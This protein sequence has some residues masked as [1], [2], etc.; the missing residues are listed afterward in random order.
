[1]KIAAPEGE[2]TSPP[3]SPG[4]PSGGAAAGDVDGAP[5]MSIGVAA[6]LGLVSS[7][8]TAF[9]AIA[10]SKVT[11]LVLGP[12]GIG[13][14]AEI[15]QLVTMANAPVGLTSGPSLIGAVAEAREKKDPAGVDAAYQTSLTGT[16]ILSVV[17]GLAAVLMGFWLLPEPWGASVWPLTALGAMTAVVTAW[18]GLV[19]QLLT[20]AGK[21]RLLAIVGVLTAAVGTVLVVIGTFFFGLAGQFVGVAIAGV[22]S[23][24]IAWAVT[25]RALPGV[26]LRP[27]WRFDGPYARRALH[28]GVAT[29]VAGV[30]TQ[31]ILFSIRWSLEARGGPALNG[32]FQAAWSIGGTYFALVLSS[33][34]NFSFP[35]YAAAPTP[36]ALEGEIRTAVKFILRTAPPIILI[37]IAFRVEIVRILYSHKF[38]DATDLLGLQMAGDLAKAVAWAQAGPL[39]YR[40]KV[41]AY[42]VTE[43]VGATLMIGTSLA[44][45][46]LFGLV[47]VGYAYIS[48]YVA[49]LIVTAL[50]V[51]RACGVTLG[52]S[53][54]LTTIAMTA[55]LLAALYAVSAHPYARYAVA[56]VAIVWAA[57]A[58]IFARV[59]SRIATR[60]G[61]LRRHPA[62]PR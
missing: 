51:K 30:T 7:V 46:P 25:T 40:G 33:L 60:L 27:R 38:D 56:G 19:A 42:L 22:A 57:R 9:L 13:M 53:R 48:T 59:W 31:A 39:L 58:G 8:A 15:T 5:A 43:I 14:S 1:M 50:I 26:V 37:A 35:R 23:L 45:I 6:L 41:N 20:A 12:V 49:Y 10:R 44:L 36:S 34:G 21:L 2:L 54:L 24:P 28:V 3:I 32:Q 52:V 11:A 61:A 47:G 17:G 55:A 18:S 4:V 16:L 29:L 62:P